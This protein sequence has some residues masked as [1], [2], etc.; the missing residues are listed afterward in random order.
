LIEGAMRKFMFLI[1]LVFTMIVVTGYGVLAFRNRWPFADSTAPKI[2][3]IIPEQPVVFGAMCGPF[4][5]Q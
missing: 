5:F 2:P 1:V 4:W 3:A